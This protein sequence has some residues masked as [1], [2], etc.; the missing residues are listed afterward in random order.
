[1]KAYKF[2]NILLPIVSKSHLINVF[3]LSF[4]SIELENQECIYLFF[5]IFVCMISINVQLFRT[6]NL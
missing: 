6:L 2:S 4:L 5:L 1:M 3:L